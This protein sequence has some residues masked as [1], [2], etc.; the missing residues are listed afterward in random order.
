MYSAQLPL[1]LNLC[2]KLKVEN[3]FL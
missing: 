3:C 2:N 1:A